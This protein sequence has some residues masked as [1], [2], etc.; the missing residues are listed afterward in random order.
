[1]TRRYGWETFGVVGGGLAVVAAA[2]LVAS[3][4]GGGG[5]G[6]DP[7]VLATIDNASV[8]KAATDFAGFMPLCQG[9]ASPSSLR[10]RTS[11][12]MARALA[13]LAKHQ[14]LRAGAAPTMKALAYTST[15]P[16]PVNGTCGGRMSYPT[17]SHTN[18]VTTAVLEFSNFCMGSAGQEQDIINGNLSFVN[19]ATPTPTGPITSKWEGSTTGLTS[20]A[21]NAAGTTLSSQTVSFDKLA[22]TVGVPGG[23]PTSAQPD[24]VS[25]AELTL[26]NN[27]TG[28]TYRQ[29]NYAMT[30]FA[31]P[32]GGE[33][34]SLSGRGYRSD[35]SYFDISTTTPLVMDANGAYVGGALTF[36]GAGGNT[37]VATLVPGNTLQATLTV[38]GTPLAGLPACSK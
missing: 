13:L 21:K 11:P 22:Y 20:V 34:M 19:T 2:A 14:Q 10:G 37:A 3:C 23:V 26:K 25:A 15:V 36:S 12:A 38:N 7:G 29:T 16:A 5:G 17:Y 32:T 6:G 4:G 24:T 8:T 1:M 30:M 9:T 27:L 35:G 31:T 18:G 28:K 33:Q